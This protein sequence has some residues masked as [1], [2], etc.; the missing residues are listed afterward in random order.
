MLTGSSMVV[1]RPRR[2]PRPRR[3]EPNSQARTSESSPDQGPSG[4][5]SCRSSHPLAFRRNTRRASPRHSSGSG[6]IPKPRV[7][8]STPA[9][10]GARGPREH[11]RNRGVVFCRVRASPRKATSS[12]SGGCYWCSRCSQRE[13]SGPA[14]LSPRPYGTPLLN[15]VFLVFRGSPLQNTGF[16]QGAEVFHLSRPRMPW[17]LKE[18]DGSN[19][20]NTPNTGEQAISSASVLSRRR[21]LPLLRSGRAASCRLLESTLIGRSCRCCPEAGDPARRAPAPGPWGRIRA[22]FQI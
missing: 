19:T 7:V 11:G 12:D 1:D 9:A 6:S 4:V 17:N 13:V 2:H 16:H 10:A 14:A 22:Q 15:R 8:G 20:R 18:L 3:R 21:R 5:C